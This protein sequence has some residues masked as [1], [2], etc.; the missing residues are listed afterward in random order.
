M[1]YVTKNGDRRPFSKGVLAT[2]LDITG[3][4]LDRRYEI[5]MEIDRE[6]EGVDEI[7][8]KEIKRRVRRKLLDQGLDQEEKFYRVLRQLPYL[9]KPFVVMIGGVAGTGKST[10]SIRLA[11]LLDITR[12]IGTDT[13]REIIRNMVSEELVPTLHESSF[14]V[15]NAVNASFVGDPLMYGFNQQVDAVSTGIRA[16][17]DRVVREGENA[18]ID[19]V[20]MVPGSLGMNDRTDC[21]GFQYVLE[22]PDVEEHKKR[23]ESRAQWSNRDPQRYIDRIDEIRALQDNIIEQAG[24]NGATVL[25]N[26]SMDQTIREILEDL[27]TELEPIVGNSR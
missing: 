27:T 25:T 17:I 5:V 26:T 16:V 1:R 20:H 3:M 9:E 13:I 11:H 12:I 2:S 4:S 18:I 21:F 14:A 10:I 6:L 15:D 19:G 22:L 23:F 8:S 7:P 24:E